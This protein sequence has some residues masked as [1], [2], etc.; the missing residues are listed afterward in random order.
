[1][2]YFK[3]YLTDHNDILHTSHLHRRDLCR[4]SL[5][6]VEYILNQST[7]N[8]GR[9]SYSIEIPSV[10]RSPG[11]SHHSHDHDRW[12]NTDSEILYTRLNEQINL[13][14]EPIKTRMDVIVTFAA[15]LTSNKECHQTY[16]YKGISA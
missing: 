1:M 6:S 8:F 10:G 12:R 5:W 14:A 11:L 4:I 15:V 7:T 3:I 2:L 13:A 16:Q 9:I